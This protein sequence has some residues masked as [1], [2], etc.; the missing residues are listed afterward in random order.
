LRFVERFVHLD[1]RAYKTFVLELPER[2][3]TVGGA[4]D[5]LVAATAAAHGSTLFTC[6]RRAASVYE[7]YG[8]GATYLG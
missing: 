5:A 4:Y 2:A 8:V 1:A 6:D 3:V 7:A